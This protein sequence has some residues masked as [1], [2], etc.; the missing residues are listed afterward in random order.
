MVVMLAGLAVTVLA[1]WPRVSE[2]YRSG[3]QIVAKP[4]PRHTATQDSSGPKQFLGRVPQGQNSAPAAAAGTPDSEAPPAIAQTAVL[5]EEDS[6]EARGKRYEGSVRWRSELVPGPGAA[7]ELAVRALVEIPERRTTLSWFL[8][9]N[10][11]RNLAA[12]HTVE[13]SF[14]L[15]ADFQAGGVASVPGIMMKQ[16]EEVRGSPLAKSAVKAMKGVFTIELSAIDA[17]VQRNV[18]LLKEQQWLD[19]PIVYTNGSRALLAL[20]KGPPGD[21]AFAEVFAAREKK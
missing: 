13:I 1:Q 19:I 14:N 11:D 8:R 20:E 3:A 15:P 9:R 16:S 4:Q 18:R 17:D 6:S 5:Y 10:T 2:L 7:A 12:S 21:R